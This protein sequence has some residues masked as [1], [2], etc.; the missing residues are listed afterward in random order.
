MDG[1][2]HGQFTNKWMITGGLPLWI[3]NRHKS[4]VEILY[5]SSNFLRYPKRTH[6]HPDDAE[7]V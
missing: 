5:K 3:G 1:E 7:V 2:K 4:V 6:T